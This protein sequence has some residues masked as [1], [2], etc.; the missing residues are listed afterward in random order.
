MIEGDMTE[1]N[2]CIDR[3]NS[4]ITHYDISIIVFKVLKDDFRYIGS[5][6]W[7]YY[8]KTCKTWKNDEKADRLRCQI[9]TIISDLFTRRALF[10]YAES[11]KNDDVNSEI[12]SKF[13]SEK[14]LNVSSKLKNNNFISVVIREAQSFFDIHNND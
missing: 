7:E 8:D 6:Q 9:K 11:S 13:M 5:K 14:M 12:H 2:S 4:S 3:C 1:I 10:W